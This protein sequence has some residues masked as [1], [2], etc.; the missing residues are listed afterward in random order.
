MLGHVSGISLLRREV[1]FL[2]SATSTMAL[3]PPNSLP[4]ETEHSCLGRQNM[5]SSECAEIC[6]YAHDI[7]HQ[8]SL[9][10]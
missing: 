7:Q 8:E 1:L 9:G 3:D 2:F 10:T 5:N 4:I 6:Y